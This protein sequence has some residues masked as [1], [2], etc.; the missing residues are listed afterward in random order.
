M[1]RLSSTSPFA[2]RRILLCAGPGGVGKTTCASALAL[3]FAR[4]GRNVAVVTIDPSRRLAQALGLDQEAAAR[5]PQPVMQAQGGSLHALLI[6]R[7]QV[8]DTI[9]EQCSPD[10]QAAAKILKNPMYRA[11]SRRLGG[12]L[13]YA[14]MARVQMLLEDD[15]FDLI[16]VDTPPAAN[17]MDFLEAPARLRELVDNPASRLLA[18][19]GRLGLRVLDLGGAAILRQLEQM[20]GTRILSDLGAFLRE[21]SEVLRE[22]QRRG[23]DF[24]SMMQ[25]R[26]CAAVVVSSSQ[27][28][29]VSESC[30]LYH[31]LHGRGLQVDAVL[32]NRYDPPCAPAPKPELLRAW[33]EKADPHNV[34]A[35][36]QAILNT[37]H[38]AEQRASRGQAALRT[39]EALGAASL[40]TIP[41]SVHPPAKLE[42]LEALGQALFEAGTSDNSGC[43][44]STDSP[45]SRT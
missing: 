39:F 42:D 36:M 7:A 8:F 19:T 23:G 37:H 6:D 13:E 17:A 32:L 29:A 41:R 10:A 11:T 30:R 38:A 22:F 25:S 2:S 28:F 15:R 20:A 26:D 34:E 3:A 5:E 27:T 33:C 12:A 1:A 45:K 31:A 21:F 35:T 4:A 40:G 44:D 9:V 18:G 43:S 24:E 14:A 16:V